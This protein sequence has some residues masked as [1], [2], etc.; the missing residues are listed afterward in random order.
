M[1]LRLVI[2]ACS[3][4]HVASW[5]LQSLD[6]DLATRIHREAAHQ[7]KPPGRLVAEIVRNF[8]RTSDFATRASAARSL[9]GSEQ[10]VLSGLRFILAHREARA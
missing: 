8:E 3:N 5:A 2:G 10:P 1:E 9:R 4:E 7:G 6:D